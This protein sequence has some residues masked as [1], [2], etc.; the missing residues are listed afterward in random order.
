MDQSFEWYKGKA[1]ER[2]GRDFIKS[3]LEHEYLVMD[4]G[5][6]THNQSIVKKISGCY[7]T[8]T[9]KRLMRMPDFVIVDKN[10]KYAELVEVKFRSFPEYFSYDKS[11]F[12]FRYRTMKEYLNYW[13]DMTMILT[14]SVEPY[15]LCIRLCDVDWN[16]HYMGKKEIKTGYP[17]DVWKFK[18]IYHL[19]KDVFPK[20]NDTIF[21]ENVNRFL[22]SS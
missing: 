16:K 1:K 12:M 17:D 14:M 10:T 11:E 18:G 20:I 7:E 21:E 6:E 13:S 8:D 2:L 19:L 4:Y 3:V 22:K 5:I 9:N 15:C